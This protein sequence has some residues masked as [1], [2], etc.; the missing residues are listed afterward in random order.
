M[1]HLLAWLYAL[2]TFALSGCGTDQSDSPITPAADGL[3]RTFDIGFVGSMAFS[4]SSSQIAIYRGP[5]IELYE[6]NSGRRHFRTQLLACNDLCGYTPSSVAFSHDGRFIAAGPLS[7]VFVM[8]IIRG[9]ISSIADH[10]SPLSGFQSLAFSTDDRSLYVGGQQASLSAWDWSSEELLFKARFQQPHDCSVITISPN[11]RVL[12]AGGFSRKISLWSIPQWTHLADLD[13]DST[14]TT[15]L[16]FD[17]TG[18][19]LAACGSY[20]ALYLWD[21]STLETKWIK[22]GLAFGSVVRAAFGSEG[23]LATNLTPTELTLIDVETGDV[24]DQWTTHS[25]REILDIQFSP[26]G[27]TVAAS[28]HANVKLWDVS[29][30]LSESRS[31]HRSHP[32]Q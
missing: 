21:I 18:K 1:R 29:T 3:L 23:L 14:F 6:V 26:D 19:F 7:Q 25:D 8:D 15:D 16:D 27:R 31:L 2:S 11:G 30:R 12:A 10:G 13:T 28:S 17:R 4:P 32:G 5:S 9:R 24:L 22:S 20:R